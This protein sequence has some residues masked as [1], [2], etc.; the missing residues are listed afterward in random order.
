MK[1]LRIAVLLGVLAGL[2]VA[3]V[4]AFAGDGY[5]T[6]KGCEKSSEQTDCYDHGSFGAFGENGDIKH[7]FGINN[8][9]A[10]GLPGSAR[11]GATGDNNS[12]LCGNPQN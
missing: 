5:C 10:D 3:V 6:Q 11:G 4:P 1:I 7:D 2:L 8:P 9:G 12:A